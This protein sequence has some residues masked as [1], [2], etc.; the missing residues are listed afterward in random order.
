[1]KTKIITL[2]FMISWTFDIQAMKVHQPTDFLENIITNISVAYAGTG[3][4]SYV[5]EAVSYEPVPYWQ[6][7]N[8]INSAEINSVVSVASGECDTNRLD[9]LFGTNYTMTSIC[10]W[11][12]STDD[13]MVFIYKNGVQFDSVFFNTATASKSF[14]INLQKY[15]RLGVSSSNINKVVN[16]CFQGRKD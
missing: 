2:I 8:A 1:M 13:Q 11:Q 9:V 5:P 12:D 14:S 3:V 4:F 10:V 16:F 7:T 6:M 15:D